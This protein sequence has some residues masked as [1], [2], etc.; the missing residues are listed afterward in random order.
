MLV[1]HLAR[2]HPVDVVGADT[3]MWSGR[4]S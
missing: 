3:M 1:D 2:V 4:S